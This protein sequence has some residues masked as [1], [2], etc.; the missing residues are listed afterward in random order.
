M[1]L[2][3]CSKFYNTMLDLLV[4]KQLSE[5]GR[6]CSIQ[7]KPYIKETA[8]HLPLGEDSWHTKHCHRSWVAAELERFRL[9]SSKE[10]DFNRRREIFRNR[11]KASHF[12]FA[13]LGLCDVDFFV[14]CNRRDCTK[15][16]RDYSVSVSPRIFFLCCLTTRW[17]AERFAES[18]MV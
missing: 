2:E 17:L 13:A 4:Y 11:L 16:R 9:C 5:D 1:K 7:W 6:N 18:C 12:S 15:A 8:R 14:Q 3:S 10:K